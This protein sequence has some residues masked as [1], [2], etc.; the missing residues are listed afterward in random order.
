MNFD[1][2]NQAAIASSTS[3]PYHFFDQQSAAWV[4]DYDAASAAI[5]AEEHCDN[6]ADLDLTLLKERRLDGKNLEDLFQL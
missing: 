2:I 6:G 1:D 3:R 5:P 4:N